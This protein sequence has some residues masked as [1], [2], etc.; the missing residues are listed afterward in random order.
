M[1]IFKLFN[2]YI[3][4]GTKWNEF[5]KA[6]KKKLLSLNLFFIFLHFF[7]FLLFFI[8]ISF[9]LYFPSNFP[10]TK[11]NLIEL[12]YEQKGRT[13]ILYNNKFAIVLTK[14]LLFYDRSKHISIKFH[15][16]RKLVKN[17]EINFNFVDQR[18]SCRYFYKTTEN[19]CVREV[20]DDAWCD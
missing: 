14:N 7:Y 19:E 9:P 13:K 20:R 6:Y 17:Q 8:S 12:K 15:Y 5:E 11:H 18:S 3:I 1:D 16:I 4:E 2:L 10:G